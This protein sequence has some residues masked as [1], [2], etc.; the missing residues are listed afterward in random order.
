[1]GGNVKNSIHIDAILPRKRPVTK[2]MSK[3]FQEDCARVAE[4]GPSILMNFR[5]DF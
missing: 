2:V 1:M 4:E 5:I 3:R